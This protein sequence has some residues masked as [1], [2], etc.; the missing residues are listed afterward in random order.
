VC[1][2]VYKRRDL[3]YNSWLMAAT[4]LITA[5]VANA[6]TSERGHRRRLVGLGFAVCFLV[7][8]AIV[9]EHGTFALV[10]ARAQYAERAHTVAHARAENARVREQ[11]R[12][13]LLPDPAAI[14]GIARRELG[15][16]KPGEKVFVI[17]DAPA[18]KQER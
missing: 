3:G 5:G 4:R 2:P 18:A 14:E 1:F 16:V 11:S 6:R 12:R 7:V 8:N 13:L 17:R 15:L 10:R 9:G